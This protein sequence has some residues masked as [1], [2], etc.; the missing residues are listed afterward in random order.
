MTRVVWICERKKPANRLRGASRWNTDHVP[1]CRESSGRRS[2]NQ[3]TKKGHKHVR[4]KRQSWRT[5]VCHLWQIS[6]Q[7]TDMSAGLQGGRATAQNSP[8]AGRGQ[9]NGRGAQRPTLPES[10]KDR[11]QRVRPAG[12]SDAA[13]E[14]STA[15]RRF[16]QDTYRLATD[17]LRIITPS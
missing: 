9:L 17:Q 15:Q 3:A 11:W 5:Q 8:Y 13:G 4:R 14:Y 12:W 1:N 6:P 7:S 10:R 2:E 16:W